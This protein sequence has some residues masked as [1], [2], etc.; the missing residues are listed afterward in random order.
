M[1]AGILFSVRMIYA[2]GGSRPAAIRAGARAGRSSRRSGRQ[3][4]GQTLRAANAGRHSHRSGRMLY[5]VA[6]HASNVRTASAR[7]RG[8]FCCFL[9]GSSSLTCVNF[10]TNVRAR[11]LPLFRRHA[12]VFF[13]VHGKRRLFAGLALLALRNFLRRA[14]CRQKREYP[15]I[16]RFLSTWSTSKM[17][18]PLTADKSRSGVG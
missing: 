14:R 8:F 17:A 4:V 6:P 12:L 13:H 11:T 15:P 9:S 5:T 3:S 7:C 2:F 1:F 10:L 16:G 18:D